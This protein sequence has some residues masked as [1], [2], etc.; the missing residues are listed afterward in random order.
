VIR[1]P[2]FIPVFEEES[3]LLEVRVDLAV[4]LHEFGVVDLKNFINTQVNINLVLLVE[5][6]QKNYSLG[7]EHLNLSWVLLASLESAAADQ[8]LDLLKDE[9]G[10]DLVLLEELG[11][12]HESHI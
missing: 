11:N 5:C 9:G 4:G 1:K 6:L 10:V 3:Y 7:M 8:C 2:L 12:E